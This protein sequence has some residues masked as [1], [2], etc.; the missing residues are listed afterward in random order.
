MTV[1]ERSV[2]L[3]LYAS[4]GLTNYSLTRLQG[5]LGVCASEG[6]RWVKMKTGTNPAADPRRIAAAREARGTAGLFI[7][8]NSAP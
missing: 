8:A 7:D 3:C 2:I 4:G 5:Q 1:A 6:M